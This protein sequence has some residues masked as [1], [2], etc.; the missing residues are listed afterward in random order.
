MRVV[1]ASFDGSSTATRLW[2]SSVVMAKPNKM[3]CNTGMPNKINI[4][5]RSRKMWKNSIL[6]KAQNCFIFIE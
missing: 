5:R 3:I 1:T 2:L 6:I 4:V